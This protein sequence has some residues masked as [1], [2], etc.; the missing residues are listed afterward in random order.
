MVATKEAGLS[1]A[2]KAVLRLDLWMT[3][4]LYLLQPIMA[5]T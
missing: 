4:H 3:R 5:K 1:M 2:S